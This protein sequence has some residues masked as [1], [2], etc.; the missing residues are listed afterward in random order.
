MELYF[1]F[2]IRDFG[3]KTIV[4]DFLPLWARGFVCMNILHGTLR[5][6]ANPLQANLRSVSCKIKK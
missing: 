2:P 1:I 4:F 5:V 6:L 3:D